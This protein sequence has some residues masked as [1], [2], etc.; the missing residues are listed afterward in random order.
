MCNVDKKSLHGHCKILEYLFYNIMPPSIF[1]L[2]CL[3]KNFSRLN[4]GSEK[5]VPWLKA[6]SALAEDSSLFL[7]LYILMI[8]LLRGIFRRK[9]F[10]VD[11]EGENNQRHLKESRAER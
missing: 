2:V 7:R 4:I 6:Y 8:L 11:N 10:V 3:Y 1:F 5:M 9:V